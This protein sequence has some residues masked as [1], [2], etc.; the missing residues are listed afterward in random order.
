MSGGS[1]SQGDFT[2][3]FDSKMANRRLVGGKTKLQQFDLFQQALS[4]AVIHFCKSN[5]QD[6][7]SLISNLEEVKMERPLMPE[8]SLLEGAKADL[9]ISDYQ[10]D[11]KNW[12][13]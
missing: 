11:V 12:K 10:D 1:G 6:V 8:D 7:Q 2:G 5:C 4:N 3:Q 13:Q 9:Y